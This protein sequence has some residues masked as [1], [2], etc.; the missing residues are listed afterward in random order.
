[1]QGLGV[2]KPLVYAS[3]VVTG[4]WYPSVSAVTSYGNGLFS[5][6]YQPRLQVLLS[7]GITV[8]VH[9][10]KAMLAAIACVGYMYC[11]NSNFSG[12]L[13]NLRLKLFTQLNETTAELERL[14]EKV[15]Q[16][17]CVIIT[18]IH[19]FTPTCFVWWYHGYC[20][21]NV[22]VDHNLPKHY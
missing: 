5:H 20:P 15:T 16:D 19:V 9:I 2:Y 1:M 3:A 13:V 14:R 11:K 6:A 18:Y 17:R 7:T 21:Y 22:K 10:R 12:K 8:H 4:P